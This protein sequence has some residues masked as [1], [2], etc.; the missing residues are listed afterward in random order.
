MGLGPEAVPQL[1]A[2]D[3]E[4]T[5]GSHS[6]RAV[7]HPTHARTLQAFADD[8]AARFR[9]SAADVPAIAPVRRV[10][11]AMAVV[12]EVADQ[13][14]Q[15]L[16]NLRGSTRRQ[17]DGLQVGKQCFTSLLIENFFRLMLPLRACRVVTRVPHLREIT[18]VFGRMIPIQNR[19]HVV[20][21]MTL[22]LDWYHA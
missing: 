14:A 17:P 18:Q 2:T 21:Q 11:R 15:L 16:L 7:L 8:L 13:L 6:G 19:R 22:I 3:V 1:A 10:V 20:G 12:L 4:S 5:Q 9:W